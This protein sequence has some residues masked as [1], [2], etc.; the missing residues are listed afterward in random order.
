MKN[1][2]ETHFMLTEWRA[3]ETAAFFS[4]SGRRISRRKRET[5]RFGVALTR[6]VNDITLRR[7]RIGL[8]DPPILYCHLAVPFIYFVDLSLTAGGAR[9]CKISF[10]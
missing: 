10:W 7:R 6:T 9:D 4:L 8:D 5:P 2:T 3:G 1:E